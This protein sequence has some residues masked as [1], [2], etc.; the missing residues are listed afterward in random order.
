MVLIATIRSCKIAL[1]TLL[2]GATDGDESDSDVE[3]AEG[4]PTDAVDSLEQYW[5][6]TKTYIVSDLAFLWL[7]NSIL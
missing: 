2:Q 6:Y 3:E 1:H 5:K 4:D 7:H